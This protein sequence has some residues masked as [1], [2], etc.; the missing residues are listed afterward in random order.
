MVKSTYIN[1]L[2]LSHVSSGR[3]KRHHLGY[4]CA[5]AFPV[6]VAHTQLKGTCWVGNTLSCQKQCRN[7]SSS[8]EL[9]SENFR[10]KSFSYLSRYLLKNSRRLC[11]MQGIGV[12]IAPMEHMCVVIN[13]N[14]AYPTIATGLYVLQVNLS[15]KLNGFLF[16]VTFW[17]RGFLHTHRQ[18]TEEEEE[19][20][21]ALP[22][23]KG[24]LLICRCQLS[25]PGSLRC[26]LAIVLLF[27]QLYLVVTQVCSASDRSISSPHI[28][29]PAQATPLAGFQQNSIDSHRLTSLLCRKIVVKVAEGVTDTWNKWFL[30]IADAQI[31]L[32][33]QGF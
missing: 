13:H 15:W 3:A 22:L 25:V 19:L 6:S 5:F 11:S 29:Q 30:V 26:P 31:S 7:G 1:S 27:L 10:R 23:D 12:K 21:R 8:R 17:G 18:L 20:G 2:K 28:Y 24:M 4:L 32:P 9:R 14:F 33:L 16:P